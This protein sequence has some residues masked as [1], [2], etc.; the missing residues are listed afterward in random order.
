MGTLT[1]EIALPLYVAVSTDTGCF[2]YANTTANTPRVAAQLMEL[3][4]PYREINKR[5]FRTKSMTRLRLESLMIERME[6]LEEGKVVLSGISLADM[7][8]LNAREE[9]VED[10]AAFLGQIA[11]VKVSATIRE[12]PEG[13]CKISR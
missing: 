1:P 10:I 7:D 9:D 12:L 8:R 2:A 6:V 11:G 5:H 3:G 13:E 4:V